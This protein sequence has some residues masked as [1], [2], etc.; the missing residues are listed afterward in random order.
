MG[1]E[2]AVPHL[3]PTT[4]TNA[5]QRAVLRATAANLRDHMIVS[6]S[7]RIPSRLRAAC[8]VVRLR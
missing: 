6:L 7:E 5:E 1:R 3:S 4:L 2:V 8:P